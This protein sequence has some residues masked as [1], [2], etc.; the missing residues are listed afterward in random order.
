MLSSF[1]ATRH[2]KKEKKDTA[3]AAKPATSLAPPEAPAAAGYQ[4][5][6]VKP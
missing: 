3:V 2:P 1:K 6:R 4:F 5:P